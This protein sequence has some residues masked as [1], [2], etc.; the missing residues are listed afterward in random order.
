MKM[1]VAG[2]GGAAMALVVVF[3]NAAEL[4]KALALLSTRGLPATPVGFVPALVTEPAGLSAIQQAAPRISM[5]G[6]AGHRPSRG[7]LPV[8]VPFAGDIFG[9]ASIMFFGP[10]MA[11]ETKVRL[12]AHLSGDL[13]E[14]LPYL[15]AEMRQAC[16]NARG[17]SLTFMEG[18]RLVTIYARRVALGKADDIVDACRVLKDLRA[19]MNRVWARRAAITPSREMRSKPP[20]L[21]V[22]KRLPRTNCGNCGEATCMAFAAKLWTGEGKLSRCTPVFEGDYRHLR[23]ALVEIC[24]GLGVWEPDPES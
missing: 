4:D 2:P 11:D 5:A 18:Y 22:Y 13:T 16:Y 14:V 15:N 6:W 24:A 19:R 10:C 17:P 3:P 7:E 21:E 8:R 1:Q 23:G 12:V 20:V 9:E